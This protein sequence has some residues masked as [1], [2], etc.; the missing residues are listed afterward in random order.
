MIVKR[1][2]D[3]T[4]S[5]IGGKYVKQEIKAEP[6]AKADAKA[7]AEPKSESKPKK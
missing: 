1:T 6:E 3:Y 7:K 2:K 5:L 4:I